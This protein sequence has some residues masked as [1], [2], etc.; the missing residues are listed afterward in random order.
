MLSESMLSIGALLLIASGGSKIGD[1]APTKGALRSAHLP[2]TDLVVW[3]LGAAEVLAGAAALVAPGPFPAL[4]VSALYLGFAGFV[5]VAL[6]RHLPL[7]S[8]GCFGRSDTPPTIGHVA[9]NL[10]MA[11]SVPFAAGAPRLVDR[12]ASDASIG[13]ALLGFSLLGAFLSYLV[14]ARLPELFSVM[15]RE[16]A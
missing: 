10:L 15:R 13:L 14:L 2:A 4:A 9:Y 6:A 16:T 8:C 7:Q 3:V 11:V 1:A 12:I 5:S